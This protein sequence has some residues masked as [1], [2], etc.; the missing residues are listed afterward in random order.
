MQQHNSMDR[1]EQEVPGDIGGMDCDEEVRVGPEFNEGNQIIPDITMSIA[2]I[3]PPAPIATTFLPVRTAVSQD[4]EQPTVRAMQRPD[5]DGDHCVQIQHK[6][7]QR[8]RGPGDNFELPE[9]Q[10]NAAHVPSTTSLH[11]P[12]EA[13]AIASRGRLGDRQK[14][15]LTGISVSAAEEQAEEYVN[16]WREEDEEFYTKVLG[17]AWMHRIGDVERMLTLL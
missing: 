7:N 6:V 17:H 12:E 5:E 9:S 13:A 15:C 10:E 4:V 16:K 14:V 8:K 2:P 11:Q 3:T 1:I